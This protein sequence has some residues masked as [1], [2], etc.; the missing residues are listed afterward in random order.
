MKY[1][2]EM[3]KE[4]GPLP[5]SEIVSCLNAQHIQFRT[6]F[7]NSSCYG[8]ETDQ[9]F[10][11]IQRVV[12]RLAFSFN[13]NLFLFETPADMNSLIKHA[14]IHPLSKKGSLVVRYR[15]RSERIDSQKVVENLASV[16][17]KNRKVSL[18]NPDIEIRALITDEHIYVG[19]MLLKIDRE[20]FER[21]KAQYRPFF[22]PIS[23]HPKIAR[24][25]VN[26]SQVE[27]E[28]TL[29][30][31]FCGTGG[32]LIEAGLIGVK[33]IGSDVS[34][35]MI[36]GTKKN[37]SFYDIHPEKLF[38]SDIGKITEFID[39]TVDV[40]VTDLPYG[41]ATST[42]GESL[43]ELYSRSFENIYKVLTPGG[44]AVCGLPSREIVNDAKKFFTIDDTYD[45]PVHRS[46]TR[47]FTVLRK[48][49]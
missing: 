37:L 18:K 13:L 12:D 9:G 43:H 14:E 44:R 42:L 1:F 41:K 33:V 36:D 34:E 30:D 32:I 17:T 7:S 24:A 47:Y 40:V 25:L 20:Q 2:F 4:Y 15:N 48:Q 8:I 16:Y 27:H 3:S 6:I 11:D 49:P 38:T 29:Y 21:R 26:L 23:M 10:K 19:K 28:Q 46:L 45:I 5:I 35:K 22:S 39:G 31:P